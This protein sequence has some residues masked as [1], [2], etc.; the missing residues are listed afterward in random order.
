MVVVVIV[1]VMVVWE[2]VGLVVI[3]KPKEPILHWTRSLTHTLNSKSLWVIVG[4]L[5]VPPTPS[6][7]YLSTTNYC[8]KKFLNYFDLRKSFYTRQGL[9][10]TCCSSA[11]TSHKGALQHEASMQKTI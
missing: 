10:D 6:T 3:F 2:V 5:L 4:P 7:N 9:K 11:C 8:P 1:I